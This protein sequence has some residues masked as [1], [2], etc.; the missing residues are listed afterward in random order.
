M[1]F[2]KG[3]RVRIIK[4]DKE[5]IVNSRNEDCACLYADGCKNMTGTIKGEHQQFEYNIF[6]EFDK[7]L[8]GRLKSC[9]FR[10]DCLQLLNNK[11]N[12]PE[13]LFQF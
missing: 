10:Q 7:L 4:L 9:Y 2:N 12:L 3:D 6:V 11:F 1:K 13:E 5:C 8:N